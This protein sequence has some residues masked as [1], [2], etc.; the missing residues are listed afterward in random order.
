MATNY[1]NATYVTTIANLATAL[2]CADDTQ[3]VINTLRERAAGLP[4]STPGS[5]PGD[6]A[7]GQLTRLANVLQQHEGLEAEAISRGA[8]VIAGYPTQLA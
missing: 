6:S 4:G 1:G 7:G 8:A 2:G 3:T 5:D